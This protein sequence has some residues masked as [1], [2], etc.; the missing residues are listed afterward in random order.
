MFFDECKR[1]C[2]HMDRYVSVCCDDAVAT[3]NSLGINKNEAYRHVKQVAT[4]NMSLEERI[5][6][7]PLVAEW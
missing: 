5:V 3:L 2:D 1:V 4:K 7:L 6:W